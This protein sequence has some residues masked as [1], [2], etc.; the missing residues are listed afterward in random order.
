MSKYTASR[1]LALLSAHE[2]IEVV[3]EEL[4]K[5]IQRNKEELILLEKIVPIFKNDIE[6][7]ENE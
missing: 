6:E 5:R 2:L 1:E 4:M 3:E 7:V